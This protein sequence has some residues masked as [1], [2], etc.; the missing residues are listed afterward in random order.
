VQLD[1]IDDWMS[2]YPQ[3][4]GAKR[5]G[6]SEAAARRTDRDSWRAWT[7][8]A[9]IRLLEGN[10]STVKEM[11]TLLH[12]AYPMEMRG[13]DINSLRPRFSELVAV[14]RVTDTDLRRNG[15]TVWKLTPNH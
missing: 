3:Q 4:A 11:L 10:P 6:A 8:M 9:I 14:N 12:L 2:R 7:H 13:R 15:E 1:L 5:A